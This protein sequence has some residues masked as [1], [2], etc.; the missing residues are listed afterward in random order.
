M[1]WNMAMC[2]DSMVWNR[3]MC[4]NA[5]QTVSNTYAVVPQRSPVQITY[6][7]SSAYH[8]QHVVLRAT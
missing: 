7:T 1:E 5:L 6:N 8:A 3:A 2:K 4:N